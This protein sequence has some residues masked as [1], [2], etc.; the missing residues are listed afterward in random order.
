MFFCNDDDNLLERY[1]SIWSKTEELK[2][3]KLTA[4]PLNDD[5]YIK[6]KIKMYF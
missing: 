2:G 1:K 5:R 6:T 4:L 3:V